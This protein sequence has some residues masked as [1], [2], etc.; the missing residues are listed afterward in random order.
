MQTTLKQ[1]IKP[2]PPPYPYIGLGKRYGTVVLFSAPES[3]TV[4]H[5]GA[6]YN[7][8]GAFIMTWA[9]ETFTPLVGEITL[10]N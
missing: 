9:E 8:L 2:T 1:E 3:G 7:K 5:V 10:R 6:G 4:L